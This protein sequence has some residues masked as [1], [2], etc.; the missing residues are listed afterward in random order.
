MPADLTRPMPDPRQVLMA[1]TGGPTPRCAALIG[2]IGERA[3]CGI[4]RDRPSI[5]R[6]V[7]PSFQFGERDETC[8]AARKRHG[9]APLGPKDWR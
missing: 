2:T 6:E 5:C 8:D 4:Y 7:T 9:L 3:Q 1:G